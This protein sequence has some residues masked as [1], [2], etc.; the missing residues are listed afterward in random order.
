M[1]V[2]DLEEELP[3]PFLPSVVC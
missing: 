3:S 1:E 2:D